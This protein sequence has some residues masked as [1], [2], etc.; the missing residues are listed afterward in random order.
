MQKNI[1]KI[2]LNGMNQDIINPEINAKQAFEIK[3]FRINSTANSNSM[4]LTSE[5]GTLEIPV[6]YP[7]N[8]NDGSN[9]VVQDRAVDQY[10][11]I[12]YCVLNDFI[13]IFVC[14]GGQQQY[15][16]ILRLELKKDILLYPNSH[17]YYFDVVEL[18]QG[19]LGFDRLKKIEA[20]PCYENENIQ[21]IYWID[22]INYP[23]VINIARKYTSDGTECIGYGDYGVDEDPFSFYQSISTGRY[24]DIIVEKQYIGGLFY[25]GVIQYAFSFYN[26]NSQET[27]IVYI[28]PLNYITTSERGEEP[29]KQVGCAFNL[30][31]RINIEDYN[32]FEN[33]RVYQIYR[34]SL[35]ATPVVKVINDLNVKSAVSYNGLEEEQQQGDRSVDTIYYHIKITDTNETGYDFDAYKLLVQNDYIKPNSFVTKDEKMFFG[36]YNSDTDL[37]DYDLLMASGD[38]QWV[39]DETKKIESYDTD[40]QS[41]YNYIN[42]IIQSNGN[43]R[44][45]KTFKHNE[46]YKLG[47]QFQD[48][49]G[50]WS[51]P[52]IIGTFCNDRYPIESTGSTGTIY[53]PYAKYTKNIRDLMSELET[54]GYDYIKARPIISFPSLSERKILCQGVLNPTVFSLGDRVDGNCYS[55]A[56]WF[57]RPERNI[58][59]HE[60]LNHHVG[61]YKNTNGALIN[62][63]HL[64]SIYDNGDIGGEIQGVYYDD[65]ID[66]MKNHEGLPLFNSYNV[67]WLS[68][69]DTEPISHNVGQQP[70][71]D[72]SQ[73]EIN[74]CYNISGTTVFNNLKSDSIERSKY[75]DYYNNFYIDKSTVTLNSPEIQFD[76]NVS[77]V[78]INQYN[79]N[80]VGIISIKQCA[81]N[82]RIIAQS[83]QFKKNN[84]TDD[85]IKP[86]INDYKY[87]TRSKELAD[88][89]ENTKIVNVNY[90]SNGGM[91]C[92]QNCWFDDYVGHYANWSSETNTSNGS[93]SRTMQYD[94]TGSEHDLYDTIYKT[95][96]TNKKIAYTVYPWH[97]QYLGNYSQNARIIDYGAGYSSNTIVERNISESGKIEKKVL[98]NI[99]F[100]QNTYYF[101][102]EYIT[103]NTDVLNIDYA[104][105]RVFNSDSDVLLKLNQNKLYGGNINKL[106]TYNHLYSGFAKKTVGGD[107]GIMHNNYSWY[108]T[109]EQKYYGIVF[110]NYA[111]TNEDLYGYP[112]NCAICDNDIPNDVIVRNSY[113]TPL[114]VY[115][116]CYGVLPLKSDGT[117]DTTKSELNV[118]G[119]NNN[120]QDSILMKYKSLP[121]VVIELGEKNDS[122][123]TLPRFNSAT[124][125]GTGVTIYYGTGVT[126]DVECSSYTTEFL[127]TTG[128]TN[129]PTAYTDNYLFI[130]ELSKNISDENNPYLKDDKFSI[131]SRTWVIAGDEYE[132]STG[133]ISYIK[134]TEGDTYYQRYD[135]L[136]TQPY[137]DDDYQS[138]VEI[139]SFMCETRVNL[140]GRYDNNR[141]LIDNTYVNSR[142]FNLMNTAYNQ[143]NNFFQYNVIDEEKFN[144]SFPTRITWSL[145]KINGQDVDEWTR[146]NTAA[147]L[148]LDGDKGEITSLR[149]LHNNI[150]A[151]QKS[152]ISYIKYN[153]NVALSTQNGV[154]IELANSQTVQGKQYISENI[155]SQNKWSCVSTENGIFFVD[156]NTP[157]IYRL[158]QAQ[159][160]FGVVNITKDVMQRWFEKYNSEQD[161]FVSSS[162]YDKNVDEMLFMLGSMDNKS[163]LA[164]NNRYGVFS[165]FYDYVG[166]IGNINKHSFS[167]YD[168]KIYFLRESDT[169][170]NFY[171]N[172]F[173]NNWISFI[174]NPRSESFI[175]DCIFDNVWYRSDTLD[176]VNTYYNPNV[177]YN[178]MITDATFNHTF[179]KIEVGNDYQYATASGTT[180]NF[181]KKFRMWRVPVPR[182]NRTRM[183]NNWLKIKLE[184]TQPVSGKTIVRDITVD[185]FF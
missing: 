99:R 150:Y 96:G 145:N 161:L 67:V 105:G 34:S 172:T 17:G 131:L 86:F 23:R 61:S 20:I 138:V 37:V 144:N 83:P 47:L 5:K 127:P 167:I 19:N 66:R 68:S 149:R 15:D 152:G 29:N 135:C 55:Q 78:D 73:G 63:N 103:G 72:V 45:I 117:L 84:P 60:K 112:I 33:I 44:K 2:G 48:K 180:A 166:F 154:P 69:G 53:I 71:W 143:Q 107:L 115:R 157:G 108:Y 162:Y 119:D 57:F 40:I 136:K 158:A 151:F 26:K 171:A 134:W 97:R 173:N 120:S 177:N 36:N 126:W 118:I 14:H 183:R 81:G 159:G 124:A 142:N 85:N 132:L 56:S 49:Y 101:P 182:Q 18:Y 128:D 70:V 148:D 13:T 102:H 170:N 32:K 123:L 179:N 100:A 174:A 137:S 106:L 163:S 156:N 51:T 153:E 109:Q 39:V 88:G 38:V 43:S 168:N 160:G 42:Q 41:H 80:L 114:E 130:G 113:I 77:N 8:G 75:K 9:I 91:L 141:G 52:F 155:G 146:T 104:N 50:K 10:E 139:L 31:I 176:A 165:S 164:Y 28:T 79:L 98:S 12:G 178:E 7:N 133:N 185:S 121:H 59:Y 22:G 82:Y 129:I 3:N 95:F 92:A 116:W 21:K 11:I 24:N 30:D 65:W 122:D 125:I 147:F 16:K 76:D 64:E 184:D 175:S 1:I 25:S 181:I 6:I 94:L 62:C 169:Y 4:E 140:D 58:L 110:N 111:F 54:A 27:P 89:F 93:V 90:N 46:W 35:N 74:N 87:T